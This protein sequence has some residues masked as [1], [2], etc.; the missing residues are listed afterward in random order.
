MGDFGAFD[1]SFEHPKHVF[2]L[3][4]NPTILL[5]K[6]LFTCIWNFGHF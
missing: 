1:R 3:Q 4:N 6:L 2:K 5:S